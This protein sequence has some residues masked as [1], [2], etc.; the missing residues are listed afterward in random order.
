MSTL[1][2]TACAANQIVQGAGAVKLARDGRQ[3]CER[4]GRFRS[5]QWSA[6]RL[7]IHGGRQVGGVVLAES[8]R[9]LSLGIQLIELWRLAGEWR[10]PSAF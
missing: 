3:K 6:A 4:R 10:R 9:R 7:M 2:L 8:W 5:G 1:C